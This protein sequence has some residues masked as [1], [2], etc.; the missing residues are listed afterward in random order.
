MVPYYTVITRLGLYDSLIGLIVTYSAINIPISM[1][2]VSSFMTSIPK[3][4]EDSAEIDGCSFWQRYS[5]I[6]FPLAN[7]ELSQLG[8]SV[9]STAGMNS[10]M[11]SYLLHL[12]VLGL[13]NSQ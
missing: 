12:E 11:H 6:V 4:L 10:F 13:Y 1:F 7:Q 8:L 5:K 9:S 3:E 2:I